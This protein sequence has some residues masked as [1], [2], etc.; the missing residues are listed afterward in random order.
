M[1]NRMANKPFVEH[2]QGPAPPSTLHAL[3]PAVR[4]TVKEG[5]RQVEMYVR[6]NPAIGIGAALCLGV[7]IGWISKRT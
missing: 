4:E 3:L 5:R 2:P 1:K 7:V 6:E